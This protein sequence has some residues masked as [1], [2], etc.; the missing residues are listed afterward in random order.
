[1]GTKGHGR[2]TQGQAR[3]S[4]NKPELWLHHHHGLGYVCVIPSHVVGHMCVG[5][6]QVVLSTLRST[7]MFLLMFTAHL[8][9]YLP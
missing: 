1:M 6:A 7:C 9:C 4:T 2:W 8:C 5:Q 3:E